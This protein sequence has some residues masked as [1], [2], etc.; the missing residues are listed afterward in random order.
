MTSP[1][2]IHT[3]T[4]KPCFKGPTEYEIEK[5]NKAMRVCLYKVENIEEKK[6][7]YILKNTVVNEVK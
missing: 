5:R 3:M 7:I 6:N 2:S 4:N 1:N